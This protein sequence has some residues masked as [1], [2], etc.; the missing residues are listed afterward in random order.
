MKLVSITALLI[1]IAGGAQAQDADLGADA[2]R[3]YCAACHGMDGLGDG[4]MTEIMSVPVPDLTQLSA[5]ND[6]VFPMLEV[7]HIIDGRTGLRGHG[8]P[9]PLY[10]AL[11]DDE[12]D[13]PGP[14]GAPIYTRGKILSIAYYLEA[15]QNQ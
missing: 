15:I 8:T 7:I 2:F 11:F 14:Y 4:S 12:L 3:T 13:S 10:G 9:M 5:N 6:G 1:A